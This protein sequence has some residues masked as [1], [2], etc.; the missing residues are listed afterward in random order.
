MIKGSMEV[1]NGKYVGIHTYQS[2]TLRGMASTRTVVDGP[3]PT[4][5]GLEYQGTIVAWFQLDGKSFRLRTGGYYTATTARRINQALEAEGLDWRVSRSGGKYVLR[6][7]GSPK[8]RRI[9]WVDEVN[10]FR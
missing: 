4:G 1:R 10:V 9:D 6:R 5:W 2:R 8:G 7:P 3:N